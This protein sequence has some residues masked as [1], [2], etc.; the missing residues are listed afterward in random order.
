MKKLIGIIALYLIAPLTFADESTL[1]MVLE[2]AHSKGFVGCDATLR[3]SFGSESV[4]YNRIDVK[5]PLALN[6]GAAHKD[7]ISISDEIMIFTSYRPANE[8]FNGGISLSIYRQVGS[9]CLSTGAS[10][11]STIN[12]DCQQFANRRSGVDTTLIEEKGTLWLRR[13][14]EYLKDKTAEASYTPMQNGGCMATFLPED[15]GFLRKK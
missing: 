10:I 8:Q 15:L 3:K 2:Q 4:H 5:M 6:E 13:E 11:F 12:L 1:K 7:R 14:V 9:Q